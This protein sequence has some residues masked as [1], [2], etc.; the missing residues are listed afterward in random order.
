MAAESFTSFSRSTIFERLFNNENVDCRFRFVDRATGEVKEFRAHQKV[1]AAVSP[2]FEVMFGNNWNGAANPIDIEDASYESFAAFM[3]YFYMDKVTLTA[4]NVVGTLHLA[5]KYDVKQLVDY[6]ENFMSQRLSDENVLAY[7]PVAVLYE[8][9]QLETECHDLF[10]LKGEEILK[11]CAFT[12]CDKATLAAFLR[13]Q[14]PSCEVAKVFD[15]C[16]KWARAKCVE[17]GSDEH[18]GMAL[19]AELGE[20]FGW[21]RFTDMDYRAFVDRFEALK[22][23]L[24][25]DE[26]DGIFIHLLRT[27]RD[28]HCMKPLGSCKLV[29]SGIDIGYTS[30]CGTYNSIL[31][32]I[33]KPMILNAVTPTKTYHGS[34][35]INFSATIKVIRCDQEIISCEAEF[36]IENRQLR[37]PTKQIINAGTHLLQIYRKSGTLVAIRSDFCAYKRQE[38]CGVDFIPILKSGN[39][40]E[41]TSGEICSI[42]SLEFTSFE[43]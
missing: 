19:R 36:T 10:R 21:I 13:L 24:T 23:M 11:S 28:R 1:L 14:P 26:S 20:C 40:R 30:H 39:D 37:L 18:A 15:A 31:F 6:C 41:T 16:V 33:S 17:S 35:E 4:E 2:V 32:K 29:F 42:E 7:Y 34:K 38:I 12:A 3:G 43:E 22:T 5:I 25:K 27:L 9:K 8:R